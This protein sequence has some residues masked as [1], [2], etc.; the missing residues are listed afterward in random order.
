VKGGRPRPSPSPR[1]KTP[2]EKTP[3][4]PPEPEPTAEPA[5]PAEAT[6]A[7]RAK[8]KPKTARTVRRT[9]PKRA[10]AEAKEEDDRPVVSAGLEVIAQYVLSVRDDPAGETGWFHEFE[11][12]RAHGAIEG[13]WHDASGRLVVE[14]VRSTAGGAL[15]GV[16]GESIVLRVREAFAAYRLFDMLDLQAGVV[17]TFTIR[18]FETAWK[19]RAVAPV[20]VERA[21]F[22]SPADLG[23]NARVTLPLHIGWVGAGGYNGEGYSGRELNRG[24]N[25]ELASG[26]HPFCWVEEGR[27]FAVIASYVGGSSGTGLARAD[28]ISGGMVWDQP[29]I[30]G[31]ATVSYA[32]GVDD[33]GD[34]RAISIEGFVRGE[35]L[36][37]FILAGQVAHLWRDIDAPERDGVLTV[38]GAGGYRPIKY[39]E[40]LLAVD[41]FV[42]SD[43]ADSGLPDLDDWRFR[44]IAHVVFDTE[45]KL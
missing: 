38:T 19:M 11:L 41:A 18:A 30:G 34:Q 33:A 31:G 43:L 27:P 37:G 44:G 35:P 17:P 21:G 42:P 13:R 20:A 4:A 26:V 12:P 39:L 29:R 8:P 25:V 32:L 22:L 1:R 14:G 9:A 3:E 6:A 24:K 28:R 36:E 15:V 23:A 10:D 7:E 40:A 16:A 5:K 2:E 45:G